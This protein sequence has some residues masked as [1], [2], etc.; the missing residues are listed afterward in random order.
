MVC[1][2]LKKFNVIFH[3]VCIGI[4]IC[5]ATISILDFLENKDVC[6]VS[7]KTFHSK[8]KY[9]Y[10]AFTM[11]L[12][13]PFV[14]EQINNF[15]TAVKA[16]Q[17][18][19]YLRGL[20]NENEDLSR[21]EYEKV[22]KMETDFIINAFV[23]YQDAQNTKMNISKINIRSWS[24]KFM[25][26]KCFTFEIPFMENELADY[27]KITFNISIFPNGIRPSD[28]RQN[29]GLQIFDH[30]PKQFGR[31]Y[32]TN[33]RFWNVRSSNKSYTMR[34]YMKGMEVLEKRHKSYEE[35]EEHIAF[36][37]AMMINITKTL[38]CR[39]PYWD[40]VGESYPVCTTKEKLSIAARMFTK[41]FCAN[42]GI[43]GPCSEVR[44]VDLDYQET[45]DD[46]WLEEGQISLRL[47]FVTKQYKEI[48][49]IRAYGM[50]SLFGNVGGFVGLLLGY[51][52]VHVSDSV[53]KALRSL[54]KRAFAEM[55]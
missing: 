35:C 51:A 7:F 33:Q 55:F 17:Y 31:S 49:Q 18:D 12:T 26:M 43:L 24:L 52:L 9:R 20:F 50:M 37:D 2:D 29:G 6:E 45:D 25:F 34:F 13:S 42:S 28:G 32:S 16:S 4:V 44:K 19:L 21:I 46:S 40:L 14:E 3:F 1:L 36:D 11:C 54:E 48:R 22:T 27:L 8:M 10:P 30:Y 5:Y 38:K 15:S 47:Y 23:Q 41:M 53:H 39:P